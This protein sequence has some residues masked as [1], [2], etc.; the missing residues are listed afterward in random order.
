L[1]G[2]SNFRLEKNS[3]GIASISAPIRPHKKAV[4]KIEAEGAK[5]KQMLLKPG[6]AVS[7]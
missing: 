5:E 3:T 2:V 6:F 7:L 1:G 4:K